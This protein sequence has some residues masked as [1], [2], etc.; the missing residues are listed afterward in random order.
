[1]DVAFSK[2]K[3]STKTMNVTDINYSSYFLYEYIGTQIGDP[4]SS[5]F[6][7]EKYA[8][9]GTITSIKYRK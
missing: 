5:L 4:I 7:N 2:K 1:M 3:L 6:L 8:V 9:I